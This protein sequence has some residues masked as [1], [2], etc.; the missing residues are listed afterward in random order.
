MPASDEAGTTESQ[1]L[2]LGSILTCKIEMQNDLDMHYSK[3]H[4]GTVVVDI[5]TIQRLVGRV[6]LARAQFCLD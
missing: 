3:Q 4:A 5:S 2:I 1:T 6:K